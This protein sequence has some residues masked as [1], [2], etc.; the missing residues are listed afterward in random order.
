MYPKGYDPNSF[1][2]VSGC[3][4]KPIFEGMPGEGDKIELVQVGVRD[5]KEFHNR[6]AESCD[7]NN[8]VQRFQNGDITAL[9]QVQGSY[10]DLT[11]MPK[12]LRGMSEMIDGLRVSYDNLEKDIK[13]KYPTFN[14]WLE[15]V[16]SPAWFDIM[17]KKEEDSVKPAGD[18][19]S[20][21]GDTAAAG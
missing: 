13:D 16:G 14:E 10:L 11:G 1:V 2:S 9:Q 4:Y 3:R 12:D 6:D 21:A 8:I 18:A 19:Y 20:S 5:L 15:N 17:K 7:I